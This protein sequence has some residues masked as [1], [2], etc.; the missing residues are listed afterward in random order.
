[1]RSKGK[2]YELHDGRTYNLMENAGELQG[3]SLRNYAALHRQ[4]MKSEF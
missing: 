3:F 2:I 4:N 1:M